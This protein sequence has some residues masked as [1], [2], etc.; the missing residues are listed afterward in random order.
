[1]Y[2]NLLFVKDKYVKAVYTATHKETNNAGLK[3][4]ILADIDPLNRAEVFMITWRYIY[5]NLN[6]YN[7]L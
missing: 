3:Q 5:P 4:L 7:L 1:M 6:N 2:R